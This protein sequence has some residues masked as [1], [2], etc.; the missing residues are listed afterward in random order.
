[1]VPQA[2]PG[3]PAE[4][5]EAGNGRDRFGHEGATVIPGAPQARKGDP[6]LRWIRA[7][8]KGW[9]PFPAGSAGHPG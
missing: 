6:A 8:M 4:E 7:R 9:I 2:T 5:G 1:V 3:A